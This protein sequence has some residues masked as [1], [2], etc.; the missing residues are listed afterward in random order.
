MKKITTLLLV[1]AMVLSLC[2]CG[3]SNEP[4]A[5]EPQTSVVVVE[6]SIEEE[7][8]AEPAEPEEEPPVLSDEE[9]AQEVADLIDMI[10][11][12]RV[13]EK[14]IKEMQSRLEQCYPLQ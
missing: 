7:E 1:L 14:R 2:A 13:L 12:R 9:L 3:S 4:V 11:E 5:E 8:P 10:E 6:Q